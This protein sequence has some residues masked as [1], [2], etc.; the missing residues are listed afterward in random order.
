VKENGG[1]MPF[2][3]D[4][5]NLE[6]TSSAKNAHGKVEDLW[7]EQVP[8]LFK[9][10]TVL[11]SMAEKILAEPMPAA[12]NFKDVAFGA[13]I[14]P[15]ASVGDPWEE[16]VYTCRAS[17]AV[18]FALVPPD[19]AAVDDQT[20]QVLREDILANNGFCGEDQF[21]KLSQ[22]IM[23]DAATSIA[24]RWQDVWVDFSA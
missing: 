11:N 14:P 17:F 13:E 7:G 8:A 2:H 22:A 16:A 12:S 19:V 18:S 23:H 4:N 15:L 6:S 1:H 24:M 9:A 21:W 10:N 20:R 3:C 5:R